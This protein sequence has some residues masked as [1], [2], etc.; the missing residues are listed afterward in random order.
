MKMQ[1][2]ASV[3][4]CSNCTCDYNVSLNDE[5]NVQVLHPHMGL[6]TGHSRISLCKRAETCYCFIHLGRKS[7]IYNLFYYVH[8]HV[9]EV[10]VGHVTTKDFS[11]S[12]SL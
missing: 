9:S 3:Q 10:H 2:M 12:A 8:E 4:Q 6:D 7:A 1:L 5:M 11:A